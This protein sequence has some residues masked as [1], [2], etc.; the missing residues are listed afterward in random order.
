[1]LSCKNSNKSVYFLVIIFSFLS[2]FSVFSNE[3]VNHSNDVIL[4]TI[5]LELWA[6]GIEIKNEDTLSEKI[7]LHENQLTEELEFAIE[8][9]TSF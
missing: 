8:N 2:S 7:V 6:K 1:M 9:I 3:F 4:K 5:T